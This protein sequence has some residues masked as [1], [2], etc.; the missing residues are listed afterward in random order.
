MCFQLNLSFLGSVTWKVHIRRVTQ[1]DGV[2]ERWKLK[3]G[4]YPNEE[5]VERM[6]HAYVPIQLRM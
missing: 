5:D 3:W 2:R 6:Y 4:R 1:M